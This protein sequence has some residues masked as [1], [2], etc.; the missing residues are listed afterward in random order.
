MGKRSEVFGGS[1]RML[2]SEDC[3]DSTIQVE[4]Q[5]CCSF[6]VFL[7]VLEP[8]G[9]GP[10]MTNYPGTPRWTMSFGSQ[11]GA[12]THARGAHQYGLLEP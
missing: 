6:G 11:A 1:A 10:S 7:G 2:L 12:R 8:N 4:E 9:T 5:L 3:N